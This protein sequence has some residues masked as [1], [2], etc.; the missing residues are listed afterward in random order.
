MCGC[1]CHCTASALILAWDPT[2]A[3][4]AFTI[5][6]DGMWTRRLTENSGSNEGPTWSPRM[7][8]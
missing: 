8:R 3:S 6:P 7:D 2:V 1:S 4:R 5:S